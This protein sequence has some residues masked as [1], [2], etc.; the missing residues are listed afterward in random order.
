MDAQSITLAVNHAENN[1]GMYTPTNASQAISLNIAV[2]DKYTELAIY[3]GFLLT[4]I[5]LKKYW[6]GRAASFGEFLNDN[7]MNRIGQ[8]QSEKYMRLYLFYVKKMNIN[9]KDLAGVPLDNLDRGKQLI[10]CREDFFARKEELKMRIKEL[11]ETIKE[12][13]GNLEPN[14]SKISTWISFWHTFTE[15]EK[16]LALEQ[17]GLNHFR[18]QKKCANCGRLFELDEHHE[19]KRSQGGKAYYLDEN[20]DI[21]SNIVYY[22]MVC[23]DLAERNLL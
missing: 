7:T 20:G 21:K 10:L 4:E 5:K 2:D 15:E 18:H 22:C 19:V 6:T 13:T 14:E 1:F 17:S 12:V 9:P 3:K 23:H 16:Q 8:S 11:N